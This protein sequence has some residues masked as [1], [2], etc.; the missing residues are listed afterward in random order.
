M[1]ISDDE[2]LDDL[3]LTVN[4][5]QNPTNNTNNENNK[6]EENN[7]E[8]VVDE[9]YKSDVNSLISMGFDSKLIKKVYYFLKPANIN[10]AID[11]CTENFGIWNHD[12]Y[13]TP[14]YKDICFICG[15]PPSKHINFDKNK[16]V[17][18]D[19]NKISSKNNDNKN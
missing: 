8:E 3:L 9:K 6:N 16:K 11:Y 14:D 12:F 4:D 18:D 7:F 1:E 15:D 17:L 19:F 5:N 13:I 10:V 2:K